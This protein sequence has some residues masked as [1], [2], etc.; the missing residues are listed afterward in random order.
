MYFEKEEIERIRQ[1][2]LL[3]Y[4][5]QYEPTN[6]VQESHNSYCTK[7][8]DSL[9][10]SNGKWM[11]F[12]RNIGGRSALDYLIKVRGFTFLQAVQI[13]S[14]HN[15]E[16]IPINYSKKTKK[17]FVMPELS[18]NTNKAYWY[19]VHRSIH[20]DIIKYC[21]EN[22]LIFE[23]A[24]YHN[25]LFAGYNDGNIR[26]GNLRGTYGD[27]KGEVPG[28]D[29]LYAFKICEVSETQIL[30]VFESAI[31]LL[32]L[33]SLK[34]H[35]RK[36]WKA[37]SYISLGGVAGSKELPLPLKHYLEGQSVKEIRL[38]LDNDE[39]GRAAAKSIREILQNKYVVKTFFPKHKD[40]ND[41]LI[42]YMNNLKTKQEEKRHEFK[43]N[44]NLSDR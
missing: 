41:D 2:D 23:T 3:S 10:I 34:I 31:D 27:F 44:N 35:L 6:I 42:E 15:I 12:S 1:I 14:G 24:K 21:F 36:D 20:P 8:H 22:K 39:A 26:Y 25:V 19:L 18:K 13:L 43:K 33:I 16:I 40:I 38:Y 28:S 30:N 17:E 11:W 4:L 9:K 7:E 29:K 37:E 32:S 5:M